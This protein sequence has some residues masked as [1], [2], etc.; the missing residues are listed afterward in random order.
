MYLLFT[1]NRLVDNLVGELVEPKCIQPT[2]L[3]NHP[4]IMSPLAKPH[5]LDATKTERFELFV[6]GK[7]I[8]NAYTELNNPIV[9]KQMFDRIAKQKDEGDN[10]IPPSDESFVR[11]LEYGLPPTAGWGIGIDR[12]TMILTNKDSIREVILFP[13]RNYSHKVPDLTV[14]EE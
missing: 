3:M 13:T 7:E 11:A 14:E 5:R 12:L 8:C 9:Q 1:L 6:N 4:L 10:E 2:F